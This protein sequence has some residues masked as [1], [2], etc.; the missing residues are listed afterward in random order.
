MSR[1]GSPPGFMGRCSWASFAVSLVRGSTTTSL[2]PRCLRAR[3]RPGQSGA[4]A[5]EP[6]D[7]SGSAPSI[8]RKWVR[9]MSG[10]GMVP[11]LPNMRPLDTCLGI[12]S[13]VLALKMFRLPKA[14]KKGLRHRAPAMVWAQGLPTYAATASRPYFSIKGAR[15]DST[16]ANASSQPTST[17]RPF[18]FISGRRKRSGS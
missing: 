11:G 3:N 16:A 18:F 14:L 4:V 12:W 10:T 9:S 13:T 1:N 6:F 7:T 15:P 5:S 2:A 8:N 17:K